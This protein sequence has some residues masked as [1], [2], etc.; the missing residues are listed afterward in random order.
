MAKQS[1]NRHDAVTIESRDLEL[2]N[3]QNKVVLVDC[4]QFKFYTK[5]INWNGCPGHV[6]KK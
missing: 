1:N 4:S 2:I 6:T 3:V 5:P